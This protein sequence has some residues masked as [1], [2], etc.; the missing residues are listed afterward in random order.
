MKKLFLFALVLA[1]TVNA[2]AQVNFGIKAGLS[3]TDISPEE[4]IQ[5][6]LSLKINNADYSMHFGVFLRG[7]AGIFFIQPEALL[8]SIKAEYELSDISGQ[9]IIREKYTNVDVPVLMGL[10]LG[11]IRLGAG[12]VAHFNI[13]K[14]SDI[15][16]ELEVV[17][18]DYETLTFGYQ[19]GVGID[20]WRLNFD[21]RYEGNFNSFGDHIAL[22][23][24]TFNFSQKPSR[25]MLSAGI[26]F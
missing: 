4:I 6:E 12:P 18:R 1:A 23:G 25:I 2:N 26:R 20:I 14:S 15:N 19:A 13:G 22:G 11:P 21:L 8:N 10:K 16:P 24:N 5:D 9:S 17:S 7:Q 3:T